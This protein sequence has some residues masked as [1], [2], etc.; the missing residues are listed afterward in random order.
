MSKLKINNTILFLCDI[1]EVFRN[2]IYNS[3]IVINN[4]EY[5]IKVKNSLDMEML[6][7][8]HNK[9]A[10]SSTISELSNLFNQNQNIFHKNKFSMLTDELFSHLKSKKEIE[11]IILFGFETHVCILQTALALKN[12]NYNCY[13]ISDAVS[14]QN[15][16]DREIALKRIENEGIKLSTVESIVYELL[17]TAEH[18]KFKDIL[19]I[20]KE[21]KLK[22]SF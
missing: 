19:K 1:Q 15:K 16:Y 13:V 14:S 18:S 2:I 10:F 11:N 4:S 3:S 8:E 22:E 12:N 5:L 21:H 9:K 20:I 17:E 6:V 7:T